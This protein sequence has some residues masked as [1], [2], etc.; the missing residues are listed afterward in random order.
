MSIFDYVHFLEPVQENVSKVYSATSGIIAVILALWAL[1][2]LVGLTQRT[3]STGKAI[4]SLYRNYL[5]RYVNLLSKGIVKVLRRKSFQSQE[6]S[7]ADPIT[8]L[9]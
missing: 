9:R 6:N 8:V 2:I 7:S 1:K 4:G 3:F 5:H